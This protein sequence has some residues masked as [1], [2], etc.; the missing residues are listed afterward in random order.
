MRSPLVDR[1]PM[2][3]EGQASDTPVVRKRPRA[4]RRARPPVAAPP[5][6]ATAPD[7]E[8]IADEGW[9]LVRAIPWA[10]FVLALAAAVVFAT[11]WQGARSSNRSRAEVAATATRFVTALTNFK[12]ETIT[13]D[14][15]RIRSFAVGDFA[16]QVGQFFGPQAIDA[17]RRARAHSAG[18]VQAVFVESLHGGTASVFAVINETVTNAS[19]STPRTETLRLDMQ[20]IDTRAGWKVNQVNILQS[21]SSAPFGA[22][23]PSP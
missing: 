22:P 17:L 6:P 3:G 18:Q 4:K 15:A 10:L 12:A 8:P 13:A 9:A 7:P 1:K 20:L 21:P 19:S 16:D 11:L 14:V 2:E 5:E 23:T